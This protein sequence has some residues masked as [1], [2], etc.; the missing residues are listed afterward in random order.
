MKVN[1]GGEKSGKY[2]DA[3][4]GQLMMCQEQTI[5]DAVVIIIKTRRAEEK[6]RRDKQANQQR[7]KSCK[8]DN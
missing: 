3:L 1:G 5:T 2:N 7:N 4:N 6:M 8:H